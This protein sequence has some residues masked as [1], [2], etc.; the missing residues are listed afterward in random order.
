MA[1][2]PCAVLHHR[3]DVAEPVVRL[4]EAVVIPPAQQ[5]HDRSRVAVGVVEVAQRIERHAERIDLPVGEPL[6][7]RPVGP[8]A[9]GVAP[10]D[11]DPA[12]VLALDR[13]DVCHP[14]FA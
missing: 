5:Q 3:G 10:L 2:E 11:V 13:R 1:V 4:A 6:D 8:H 12:A 7:P 14:W 9:V